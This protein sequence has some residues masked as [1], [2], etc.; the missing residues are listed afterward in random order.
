MRCDAGVWSVYIHGYSVDAH[1]VLIPLFQSQVK[2]PHIF[3][4]HY[5]KYED[6]C[7]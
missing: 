2:H 7:E 6:L 3:H 5:V 4:L 1:L